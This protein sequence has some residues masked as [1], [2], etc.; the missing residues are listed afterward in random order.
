MGDILKGVLA[1]GWILLVGW[2]LPTA[3]NVALFVGIVAP[4]IP[5]GW[6]NRLDSFGWVQKSFTFSVVAI[7]LG[8]LLNMSQ[9]LLY[10]VLE[11]YI[12]PN[13]ISK[14]RVARQLGKK[15][16][17]KAKRDAARR[18]H[19][20][21]DAA[22]SE[23]ARKTLEDEVL[24]EVSAENMPKRK[25]VRREDL[26]ILDIAQLSEKVRR[27]PEDDKRIMPTRLGNALKRLEEYGPN[28][29]GIDSISF[30]YELYV[31]APSRLSKAMEA[32]QANVDFF[33]CLLYGNVGVSISIIIALSVHHYH[34]LTLVIA[35]LV[36]LLL[37]PVW[38][39]LAVL[40]TDDWASATRA[41]I[42]LGRKPLAEAMRLNLPANIEDES[43]AWK[44]ISKFVREPLGSDSEAERAAE[45]VNRYRK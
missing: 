32:A 17:L 33:V 13:F 8:L 22:L 9:R 27:Y 12:W 39:G 42:N 10:R 4:S 25:T 15:T 5:H 19:K 44:V 3:L 21:L 31:V 34:T 20:R 35:L 30:W 6:V 37:I 1:G 36:L 43:K 7:I 24:R 16:Y 2:I 45:A 23:Q 26:R 28:R 14:P 41:L 18:Y 11:G 40:A 29:Y 38:Y